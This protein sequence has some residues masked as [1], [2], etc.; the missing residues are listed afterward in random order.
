MTIK[1]LT[2][3]GAW[4]APQQQTAAVRDGEWWRSHVGQDLSH[5]FP[6]PEQPPII[7]EQWRKKKEAAEGKQDER[8]NPRKDFEANVLRQVS[9][10]CPSC[11]GK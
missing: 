7:P 3:G 11:A 2:R 4:Q 5:S 8:P 9:H 10:S 1:N 6:V